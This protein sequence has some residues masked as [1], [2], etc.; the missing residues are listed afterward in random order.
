MRLTR[1]EYEAILRRP[2]ITKANP[3]MARMVPEVRKQNPRPA[4]VKDA[5]RQQAVRSGVEVSVTLIAVRK[6]KLDDDNAIA[7]C[8]HLRDCI[9]RTLG[10]D[11]ADPRVRWEY[12]QVIGTRRGTIVKVEVL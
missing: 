10:V 1:E 4:L 2:A 11:D 7:S 9:A 8:K 5:P 3:N 6:G 12:G